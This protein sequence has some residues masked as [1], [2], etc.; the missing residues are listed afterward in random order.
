MPS[1]TA[2][3]LTDYLV[4]V[5]KLYARGGFTVRTILMDQ[6]F[7]MVKD[8]MASLE[9]NTT[10]AIREHV[11]EIKGGIRLVKERFR[12][13]RAIMPFQQIPKSFVIHLVYFC[14]MWLNSYPAKQGIFKK[15]SPRKI[16]IKRSLIFE[17]MREA[18]LGRTLKQMK[19]LS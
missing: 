13:T 14:V 15:L 5:S 1:R 10:T 8:K 4:K 18:Y 7:D 17:R 2:A 19:T 16:V 12:G 6:A 3:K 9:V 11:G